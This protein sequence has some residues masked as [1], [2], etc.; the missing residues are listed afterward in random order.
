MSNTDKMRLGGTE[1]NFVGVVFLSPLLR[2]G[3]FLPDDVSK[4]TTNTCFIRAFHE[5]LDNV[6]GFS[7]A[8]VKHTVF[9]PAGL[10][11][12]CCVTT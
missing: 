11:S 9:I 1:T 7:C 2:C 10:R 5:R 3:Y 6:A 12:S 4:T 8:Q